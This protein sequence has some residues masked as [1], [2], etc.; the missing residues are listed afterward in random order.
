L[1]SALA[2]SSSRLTQIE[3][4]SKTAILQLKRELLSDREAGV[5]IIQ[6]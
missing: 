6:A 1:K 3:E 4:D 2:E 5:A